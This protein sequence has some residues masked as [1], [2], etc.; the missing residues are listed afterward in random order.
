[1]AEIKMSIK[2]FTE[3][4]IEILS[5][6]CYIKAVSKKSITYTDEF[7]RIFIASY[8]NGKQPKVIFEENGFDTDIIGMER[9][10]SSSRRWR[11]AYK[12]DGIDGLC[13][14]RKLASGRPINNEL[15]IEEKYARLQAQNN[16]LK[17]ENE[18]LKKIDMMER[19]LLRGK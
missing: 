15:S 3:K 19:R 1:M 13:D 16:F 18:L 4:E 11:I 10:K 14:T 17:A 2:D 9:V 8:E 6:N 12:K 7:K 5:R